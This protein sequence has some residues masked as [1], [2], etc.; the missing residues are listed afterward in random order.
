MSDV[1]PLNPD[2]ARRALT[3]ACDEAGLDAR[4]AELIRLGENAVFRLRSTPVVAR[5]ARTQDRLPDAQREV[6]VA[7]WLD[8]EDVPAIRPLDVP[9]P[10]EADGRV[11]T[12]WESATDR[13]DYGSTAELGTLL[14]RLHDLDPPAG[15]ELPPVDPFSR[16]VR[17]IETVPGVADA[18]RAFLRDRA[19]ELSEQYAGLVYELPLGPIHGDANVGNV[20][21][22]RAGQ[23]RFMDLDGFA[24]G[25]REW[26]LILTAIYYD[27]FGW[28]TAEEYRAF[29]AAYGHDILK[30]NGYDV[31]SDVGEFLMV[32]WLMQNIG[33]DP[34]SAEE[35]DKRM[36][37]LRVGGDRGT[38]EPL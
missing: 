8:A 2:N 15:M 28:H 22:D 32:T 11:V 12:L 27:R 3:E 34:A 1:P 33:D 26:D 19:G 29:V 18:D 38:W 10:V 35:F 14:R 25:P 24:T 21:R 16:A 31:L 30:W 36:E 7:R 23:A 13:E 17:R 20:L 4:D 6:S 37:T 5:V 9:Q